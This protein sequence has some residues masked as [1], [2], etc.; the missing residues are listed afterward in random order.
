MCDCI[1]PVIIVKEL[2]PML[3]DLECFLITHSNRSFD[4]AYKMYKRS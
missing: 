2:K 3:V 4:I 1:K